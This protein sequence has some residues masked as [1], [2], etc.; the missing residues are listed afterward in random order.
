[1]VS[2]YPVVLAVVL[3]GS[4]ESPPGV[5]GLGVELGSAQ[6]HEG[7][8]TV[9]PGDTLESVSEFYLGR[10][11]RWREIWRL[12]QNLED[13][14]RIEPGQ[15]LRVL[16]EGRVP[17]EG[18]LLSKLSRQ[19]EDQLQPLSWQKARRNDLLRSQDSLRTH[20]GASAELVFF[21]D[22]HL[23]LNEKSLIIVGEAPQRRAGVNRAQIEVVL[24]QADLAGKVASGRS[25]EIEII[26]GETTA[27]P[28][29]SAS[30][31][32]ET[33]ARRPESGG[34]RLMVY[35]GESDVEAA[36]Q[37]VKVPQGMGSAI[38]EDGPPSP[39]EQLLVAPAMLEPATGAR[40]PTPR[41]SFR[42]EAVNGASSYTVEVCKDPACAELVARNT[43]MSGTDWQPERLPVAD[44]FWRVTATSAT[45]LD[46]YP[47]AAA[48]FAVLSDIEDHEPPTVSLRVKGPHL[49]P[50]SGLNERWIMGPGFEIVVD[51]EDAQ[52]GLDRWIPVIDGKE[53]TASAWRGPWS[54][55]EHSVAVIA[56]DRVGNRRQSEPLH[57]IYDD[58]PP[59][60]SWGIQGVDG[61][62][63]LES[64]DL[65]EDSTPQLQGLHTVATEGRDWRVES[66]FTQVI[67][68]PVKGRARIPGLD[69]TLKK[70]WGVWILATDD[71]CESLR[72][73]AFDIIP[74]DGGPIWVVEAADCVGNRARTS[75]P[76]GD[77]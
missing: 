19:V 15:R 56:V 44:F 17:G 6:V 69:V 50:R 8:H 61:G 59:R 66:D 36:G 30:G 1:M 5:P 76:L 10:S 14:N 46:G 29:P 75:R 20:E 37:K 74:G 2:W 70:R 16:L 31:V 25:D 28:R 4:T 11:D 38:P 51:A 18:A 54:R 49:A 22:T 3:V 7:W 45:G 42:W 53:S 27:R 32:V 33:R 24:G 63:P 39:P 62:K 57:F 43:G 9:R 58:Q 73:L 60:F 21:D 68:R 13:P 40:L 48:S 77:G 26:L 23:V 71:V 47:S 35:Q 34:A 72:P 67:L 64:I 55:G 41:P 12:N 52:S 65:T